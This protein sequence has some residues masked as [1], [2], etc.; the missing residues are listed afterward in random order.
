MCSLSLG[1]IL[2]AHYD[3]AETFHLAEVWA[4]EPAIK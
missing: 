1:F 4:K 2:K 3:P